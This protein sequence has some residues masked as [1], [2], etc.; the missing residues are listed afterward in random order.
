MSCFAG[1]L[2]CAPRCCAAPRCCVY[3]RLA[4]R[5][6]ALCFFVLLCL[7]L[8]RAVSCLG[9]LSV[10]LWSCVLGAVF[11]LVS[12]R[13][14]CF[15]VVCCLLMLLFVPSA[16]WDV[17]LCVPCPLRPVRCCCASLLSL[18]TLL[19][20]AVPRGAVLPCGV[21]VSCPAALFVW[22][23]LLMKP[24]QIWFLI[25]IKCFSK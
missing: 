14:R 13:C 15:A 9:A 12:P 3:C 20:C 11:C 16:S 6:S 22:F 17:L 5:C 21:V 10:V 24:L 25:I 4:L 18:G 8:S 23:L 1:V 19:P 2:W 7:V